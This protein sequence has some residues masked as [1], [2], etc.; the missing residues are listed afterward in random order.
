MKKK[1]ICL[2]ALLLIFVP[3]CSTEN[4]NNDKVATEQCNQDV[5]EYWHKTIYV[6]VVEIKKYTVFKG[7]T[8]W[9]YTE[10]KIVSKEYNA[11]KVVTLEG[12]RNIEK[13]DKVKVTLHTTTVNKEP[14]SRHLGTDIELD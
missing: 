6:E 1:L 9:P 13:G 4:I 7:G 3:G 5:T 14:I 12:N 2:I 8:H 10:I 11:E